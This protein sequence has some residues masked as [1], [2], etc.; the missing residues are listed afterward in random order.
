MK[1]NNNTAV[2]ENNSINL[3]V[4]LERM[5]KVFNVLSRADNAREQWLKDALIVRALVLTDPAK[6]NYANAYTLTKEHDLIIDS[7]YP[8]A[9]KNNAQ[10]K[11]AFKSSLVACRYL[12]AHGEREVKLLS[13]LIERCNTMKISLDKMSDYQFEGWKKA[14]NEQ[15]KKADDIRKK[16]QE[17]IKKIEDSRSLLSFDEC[18]DLALIENIKRSPIVVHR[19]ITTTPEAE[20]PEAET[21]EAETP[22]AEAPEAETPEAETPEAET[23]EAETPEAEVVHVPQSTPRVD[24]N[25]K[26]N[27][28]KFQTNDDT[29][30]KINTFIRCNV[31]FNNWTQSEQAELVKQLL[32]TLFEGFF[33]DHNNMIRFGK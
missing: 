17:R 9:K 20:A 27:L 30:I 1:T 5:A 26:Y 18:H 14:H 32:P 28:I 24:A 8:D 33:L 7:I 29:R 25:G 12:G 2:T 6:D 3:A 11:R 22:E 16:E 31:Q 19:T 15:V 13:Y 10:F 21:P 4:V 23:P